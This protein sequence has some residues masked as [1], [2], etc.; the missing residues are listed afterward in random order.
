[1]S[2]LLFGKKAKKTFADKT[3]FI[4]KDNGNTAWDCLIMQSC[5]IIEKFSFLK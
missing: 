5:K 1:M 2:Y 3:R 4:A